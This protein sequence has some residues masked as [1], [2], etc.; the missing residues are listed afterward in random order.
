MLL[1]LAYLHAHPAVHGDVKGSNV[2]VGADGR[3]LLADF[4]L[5]RVPGGLCFAKTCTR[6]TDALDAFALTVSRC[7]MLKAC[8]RVFLAWGRAGQ[9]FGF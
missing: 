9:G 4:D 6:P 3:F 1:A 7:C 5:C 2:L 8:G